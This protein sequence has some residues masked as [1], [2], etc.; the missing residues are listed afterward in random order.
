MPWSMCTTELARLEPL[1]QVLGHDAPKN[2]RPTN[3]NGAEQLA[4]GD[5]AR[6]FRAA[7]KAGVEAAIDEREAT[8]RRRFAQRGDG[9]GDRCPALAQ[10]LRQARRLVGGQDDAH[11]L[12]APAR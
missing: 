2:P 8:G 5:H 12:A 7:G 6:A 1:Q 4:I 3:T 11:A 9:R 10:D